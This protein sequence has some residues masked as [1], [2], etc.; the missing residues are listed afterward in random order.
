MST[1]AP[2]GPPPKQI[3]SFEV[4][5]RLGIGGMAEIFL[6][7]KRGAENTYKLLVLKRVLPAHSSSTRFRTMFGEEANL[8]TRLNHP[9]IVQVYDF[10]DYGDEGQLLSMEYVEG[11]D[12]G[13]LM[14]A[15]RQRNTRLPPWVAAYIVG[16]VAKGLHYAHERKDERGQPLGIVHRDVSPQNVLLSYEGGVKIADFGIATANMF[17]DEVGVL[18]GKFAYMSPEQACGERVD[19]R[20]DIYS[21]GVILHEMLTGR[22]L[23]PGLAGDELL[24]AVRG[25]LVEPPSSFARDVPDELDAITM[26]ALALHR[27]DRYPN[28]RELYAAIARAIISRQ[29]L[30]DAGGVEAVIADLVGRENTSP[31]VDPQEPSAFSS[32]LG[33][34][35]VAA[36]A[37]AESGTASSTAAF[38]LPPPIPQRVHRA[39]RDRA[40][41]EVRHV[42][43]LVLRLHGLEGLQASSDAAAAA[44][45]D[46]EV[47]KMLDQLAFKRGARLTWTGRTRA[48]AVV[49]LMANPARA[50]SD[51]CTLA[52]DIH[53]FLSN[54]SEDWPVPIAASIGIVRGIASGRRD[55]HGHLIEHEL[56]APAEFLASVVGDGAPG[57]STWVAGGLYRLVRNEFLWE[58]APAI[59]ID[60]AAERNLPRSMRIQRLVRPLSREEREARSAGSMS[61]LIGRDAEKADLHSAFHQV[62]SARSFGQ[63]TTIVSRVIVGEMGIGKSALVAAFKHELSAPDVTKV[64]IDC[65]PS[66]SEVP[67]SS[68]A[69]LIRA[70][71]GTSAEQSIDDAHAR[72]VEVIGQAAAPQQIAL[73]LAELA[74]GKNVQ[75]F[76]EEDLSY[77]R[78]LILGGLRA[79]LSAI[80]S[81]GSLLVVLE[82]LQWADSASL[83]LFRELIVSTDPLPLLVLLVT[84]PDE[85][86]APYL[87]NLVRIEL[88]GLRPDEQLRLVESRLGVHQGVAQVCAELVPRVAGNPFFLLEM[89]DALLERGTLEIQEREGQLVLVRTDA[90][91]RNQPLPSTLEQ[92]IG[93]RLAELPVEEREV[94]QWLAVAHG[95]LTVHDLLTLGHL[96]SEEPVIR[97]CARG[98]CERRGDQVDFRYPIA[99]DVAYYAIESEDRQLMHRSLGEHLATTPIARGLSAVIVARHLVRGSATS[100][101]AD[102]YLEAA[103]AARSAY[104]TQLATHYFHRALSLLRHDDPRRLDAHEALESIC[105]VLGRHKDR[106]KHLLALRS[107]SARSRSSRWIAVALTRTALFLSDEGQYARALPV[108]HRAV[109]ATHLTHLPNLEVEALAVL[110]ETLRELGDIQG[111]LAAC[112]RALEVGKN[113]QVSPR[114]RADVLRSRGVMLRR[115]GRV[116]EAVDCYAESIAVFRRVGA[117]RPEARARNAL[118]FAMFVL[119]RFE[120]SIALALSSI[121]IDLAI[122][123]RFQLAKTLANIGQAYARLGDFPRGLAYLKRARDA[124]ERYADQDARADT[125]LVSA[126]VM[127]ELGDIEAARNFCLDA[128]ALIAAS[129]SAY[130]E[131][132]EKIVHAMIDRLSGESP[133]A[134]TRAFEARQAAESQALV[135]FHCLATAVEAAARVDIGEPHTGILLATTAIGAIAAMQ[136]SEYGL[137]TVSMCWNTLQRAGSPQADEARRSGLARSLQIGE[138]IRDARLKNLFFKRPLVRALVEADRQTVSR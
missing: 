67:M 104:Q 8:A 79:L 108:C 136:G 68:L 1:K 76:D 119:E 38:P 84:R 22:P 65:S 11:L 88:R 25:G 31:G 134:V 60:S 83:D 122:G 98:M 107:L 64:Q 70:L 57:S 80:A 75:H 127:I 34:P 82:G 37:Q 137:E 121:N 30:V 3:A 39:L 105:R 95:P 46:D 9:N 106:R 20:S 113:A 7:K 28:A 56:Q 5:R 62:L 96:P 63:P 120:D 90:A 23:R 66:H 117:R 72:I 12:L 126:E 94:V 74:S 138:L 4:L 77:V 54:S 114:A 52:V 17:R 81:R 27:E 2:V 87:E 124:H 42:A 6:A 91:N 26:R 115:V 71:T 24:E 50:P 110:S 53:E 85:R 45:A 131:V 103:A 33:P 18:K 61:D 109:T 93:D 41:L 47:R 97:L 29:V 112:D 35:P 78:K 118:A 132:H 44:R 100:R 19:R 130:D 55:K 125:L 21:L 59:E 10:S 102:Y 40:S 43:V 13:R 16:E 129:N 128:G 14:A 49:G 51:S 116:R 58:D 15:A 111:A 92:L 89:V 123:G 135:S 32:H 86:L 99:R 48:R 36:A 69:E 133:R 73:R 101:A